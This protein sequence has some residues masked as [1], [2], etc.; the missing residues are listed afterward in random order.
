[1]NEKSKGKNNLANNKSKSCD[2]NNIN[3]TNSKS[4]DSILETTVD[5]KVHEEQLEGFRGI[6]SGI[7]EE[8]EECDK[9][10]EKSMP[11]EISVVKDILDMVLA[12]N[13]I[14]SEELP[15]K[16]NSKNLTINDK[17]K[18]LNI[19]N[20]SN[21]DIKELNYIFLIM[22]KE[23]VINFFE[24]QFNQNWT[25]NIQGLKYD[26]EVFQSLSENNQEN[27]FDVEALSETNNSD[28]AE[29]NGK[30]EKLPNVMDDCSYKDLNS[31]KEKL[32]ERIRVSD[33]KNVFDELIEA[34]KVSS[35]YI[36][37]VID[38]FS[39]L[40]NR[41]NAINNI[42]I[43]FYKVLM[44]YVEINVFDDYFIDVSIIF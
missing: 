28:F 25:D 42:N 15:N 18:E 4:I 1:M 34:Y 38:V 3:H 36:E 31:L 37:L 10:V 7:I 9:I 24:N 32:F 35:S 44:D 8:F 23:F 30:I 20:R 41:Y 43:N 33:Y 40:I 13:F 12:E 11:F 22:T 14:L 19:E 29:L 26:F 2:N 5:D 17:L 27:E 39:K 6:L 16:L 21:D